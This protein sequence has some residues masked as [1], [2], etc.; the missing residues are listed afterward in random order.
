MRSFAGGG[1][2]ELRKG[3]ASRLEGRAF[4]KNEAAVKKNRFAAFAG[5]RD[6]APSGPGFAGTASAVG[7]KAAAPRDAQRF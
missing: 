6:T 2:K 7:I 4:S 3:G 1:L 5:L